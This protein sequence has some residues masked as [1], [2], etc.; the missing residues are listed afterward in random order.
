M[1]R[2][3]LIAEFFNPCNCRDASFHLSPGN[4]GLSQDSSEGHHLNERN[5]NRA[6]LRL[7]RNGHS[8][9][10]YSNDGNND[11]KAETKPLLNHKEEV[12]RLLR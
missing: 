1:L 9:Y 11:V 5:A 4:N 10:D 2:L 6:G 8:H 7:E 3:C 12:I